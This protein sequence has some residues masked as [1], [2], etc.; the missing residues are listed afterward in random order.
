MPLLEDM[1]AIVVPTKDLIAWGKVWKKRKNINIK[2]KERMAEDCFDKKQGMDF[3]KVFD[4][5]IGNSLAVMLG[6]VEI[7]P[8][9]GMKSLLPKKPDIVEVGTV[10]VI[11]GIRPQNYDVGY[12]PDGIRFVSDSKTL[13][14]TK[15]VGKNFQNMINDLG[16]EATTIHTRFPFA[17]VG[18]MVVIPDLC[19]KGQMRDRYIGMLDRLVGR[20]SPIDV[21]HKAEAVS[22]VL[23]DATTGMLNPDWPRKKSPL[24]IE[25]FSEQVQVQYH[26]RYA[27]MAPHDKPSRAQKRAMEA[28]GEVVIEPAD[29]EEHSE[30]VGD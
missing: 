5:A 19:L 22:L 24:R 21:P 26:S 17:V 8:K 28:L 12:R 23:W 30:G 18:F 2:G 20:E 15:S 29:Q 27:G 4:R 6:R 11:G 9:P 13:N 25:R 14:D 10:R 1:P 3:S 7:D 16:A